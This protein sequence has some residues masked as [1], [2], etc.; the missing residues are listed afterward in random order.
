MRPPCTSTLALLTQ[1][2]PR[3]RLTPVLFALSL[4]A[5]YLIT[6]ALVTDRSSPPVF[7]TIDIVLLGLSLVPST[8]AAVAAVTLVVAVE[9]FF[10]VDY[11]V[12]FELFD[13]AS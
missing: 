2:R 1:S 6:G 13:L 12:R 5:A 9:V 4:L 8:L 7:F 11:I 10:A 3:P